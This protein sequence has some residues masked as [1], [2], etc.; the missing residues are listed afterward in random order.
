MSNYK[1][2]GSPETHPAQGTSFHLPHGW[3]RMFLA[4]IEVG[5]ISWAICLC[6]CGSAFW[7]ESNNRWLADTS[8]VSTLNTATTLYGAALF[9][10][11]PLGATSATLLP[12]GLTLLIIA[13]SQI[14]MRIRKEIELGA[15]LVF[16][17]GFSLISVLISFG[18]GPNA[19]T[20]RIFLGAIFV[21]F[22]SV[23]W[24]AM[25]R[26][27]NYRLDLDKTLGLVGDW[28]SED[29]LLTLICAA[30]R[31]V[32]RGLELGWKIIITLGVYAIIAF[33]AAIA[34]NY[35][36]IVEI[37]S[38]LG[39]RGSENILLVLAQLSYLPTLLVW[40][41]SWLGGTGFYL[42]QETLYAP[43]LYPPGPVPAIPVLGAIPSY[44][45]GIWPLIW[46][47]FLT[48][49][50]VSA[51]QSRRTLKQLRLSLGVSGIFTFFF[52]LILTWASTGI[53]GTGR[54]SQVGPSILTTFLTLFLQSWG[55]YAI[56]RILGSIDVSEKI[57][58]WGKSLGG[59]LARVGAPS[60][61]SVMAL[62]PLNKAVPAEESNL[63]D[64]TETSD[65]VFAKHRIEE[66]KIQNE[67]PQTESTTNPGEENVPEQNS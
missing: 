17:V 29:R 6:L 67:S 9:G 66:I 57:K 59:K 49:A 51:W 33:G 53:L 25:S 39:A 42:G 8:W 56:V 60:G 48:W 46:P 26:V 43:G 36:K 62:L 23:L 27:R 14:S 52:L 24:Q 50:A 2:P 37:T 12:S 5:L 44:G 22:L 35:A 34:I 28:R 7:A 1:N 15:L 41:L 61:K 47:I 11:Y 10:S 4:G 58:Y 38:L 30:P 55:T 31:D 21:A 32:F 18:G 64:N 45:A 54:L 3:S 19:T 63:G 20:G 40:T 16:P 13:L 65:S